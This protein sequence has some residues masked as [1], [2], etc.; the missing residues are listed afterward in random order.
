M[1]KTPRAEGFGA[2]MT[3]AI[4]E[5]AVGTDHVDFA[6][7]LKFGATLDDMIV[8]AFREP[9]LDPTSSGNPLP[10]RFRPVEHDTC[11]APLHSL[12]EL[13]D[14]LLVVPIPPAERIVLRATV[15]EDHGVQEIEPI[16]QVERCGVRVFGHP[17]SVRRAWG[18]CKGVWGGRTREGAIL[19]ALL[20]MSPSVFVNF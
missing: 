15:L 6:P 2:A 20:G 4:D 16:D 10:W 13:H 17:E 5:R 19:S 14:G 12:D 18:P 7:A 9:D 3:S 11:L 8:G 1:C